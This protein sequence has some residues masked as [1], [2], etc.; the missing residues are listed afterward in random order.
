[1][2][3][4]LFDHQ[5]RCVAAMMVNPRFGLWLEPGMG[6]TITT[7]AA[8]SRDAYRTD[9]ILPTIV[10]CP[11]SIMRSAWLK[12]SSHFPSLR[13]KVLASDKAAERLPNINSQWDIG[14]LNFEQFKMHA[15]NL[16]KRGVR[17]LVVD[18]SSKIKNYQ[19][20]ITSAVIR[21]A[22]QMD[23]VWLLSGTPA[24]NSPTEYFPQI[25]ALRRDISGDLY[26]KWVN[27]IATPQ[28][29]KLWRKVKGGKPQIQEIVTGYTQSEKQRIELERQLAQC[30]IAMRKVDALDLPKQRDIVRSVQLS[31]DE[32]KAYVQAANA[33][34]V[35]FADGNAEKFRAEAALMKL[36]QI[37]G[38]HFIS[39][40]IVKR[41]GF[42]K[43]DALNDLLDEIG[44]KQ[45]LIWA[46][47]THEIDAIKDL[48]ASRGESVEIIDG[49]TSSSAGEIAEK[50][51]AGKIKRLICQPM[52][53]GHGITLTAAHYAIY[54]SLGF[55][56]ELFKQSR[57]RIH[58]LGQDQPCT[59]YIL[60]AEDTVDEAAYGV[61]R[62]K[63]KVSDALLAVLSGNM[64]TLKD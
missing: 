46:E 28:R 25:R 63:G 44:S 42:A 1:M 3:V 57:D 35:E 2:T 48:C 7:L 24:P 31:D 45:C 33:F 34:R 51:Q 15:E 17:R 12:D 58:R 49:R 9:S 52:A 21:F 4:K 40:P 32:S 55:S 10:I 60:L 36:R 6:K 16:I 23:S 18:E 62:G 38:G 13:V 37:T 20:E 54:Y 27:T 39:G 14:I 11:K 22:D 56:Y 19:S 53:A 5:E 47:F 41:I 26:W 64:K 8:I 30:S 50:F 29:E 59:Y 61:V 43:L